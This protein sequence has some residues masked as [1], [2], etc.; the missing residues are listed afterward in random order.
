LHRLDVKRVAGLVFLMFGVS[1]LLLSFL[2]FTITETVIDKAF[3][4]EP[5]EWCGGWRL[6]NRTWYWYRGFEVLK[7]KVSVEGEGI[8]FTAGGDFRRAVERV[9]VDSYYNFTID[10]P[11]GHFCAFGFDNTGGNATSHVKF[12]LNETSTE[13]LTWR[14]MV[15]SS[16]SASA[17][18]TQVDWW[19]FSL[20]GAFLS[21]PI[22]FIL[23][24]GSLFSKK[25]ASAE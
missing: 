6:E 11:A 12:V 14:L 1:W 25:K 17:R 5:G 9:F 2:N 19:I 22:G 23:T 8:N 7:G 20:F 15:R 24:F 13:S 18:S 16:A 21:L 3:V 4:L 10:S